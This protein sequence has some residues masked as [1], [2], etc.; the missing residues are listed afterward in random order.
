VPFHDASSP[1][2]SG[3]AFGIRLAKAACCAAG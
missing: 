2:N 1:K 3:S